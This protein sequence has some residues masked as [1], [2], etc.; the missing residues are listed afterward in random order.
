MIKFFRNDT[1]QHAAD[2]IYAEIVAQTR[3]PEFYEQ[4]AV[5]DTLDGRFDLLVMHA[6]LF[7]YRLKD[8][9]DT[10]G[11][12]GQLVFDTMFADLDQNLREMGVGDMSIGKKVRKMGSAF[13]GRTKVYDDAMGRYDAEP[14][15]LIDAVR[16]NVFA[17]VPGEDNAPRL[18]EYMARC[19]RSLRQQELGD[20]LKGRVLF[21]E[22]S[23]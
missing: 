9:K 1:A 11:H 8:E 19:S 22:P 16:R 17:D 3:R 4:V 2:T 13:Y 10:A 23:L 14:D 20:L 5:P 12:L 18:A 6:F 15:I 7:F 21:P